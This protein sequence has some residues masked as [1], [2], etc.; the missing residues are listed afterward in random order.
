M[1]ATH[2]ASA[3]VIGLMTLASCNCVYGV[4]RFV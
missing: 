2:P 3:H 1:I 4:G